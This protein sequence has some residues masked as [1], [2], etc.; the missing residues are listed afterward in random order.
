MI[1][2]CIFDLDGTVLDTVGSIAHFANE[3]LKRTAYFQ[4]KK[5]NTNISQ[6]AELQILCAEC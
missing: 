6:G 3:A 2:L 4:S 5:M 1:K